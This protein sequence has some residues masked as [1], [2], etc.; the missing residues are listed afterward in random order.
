MV[1]CWKSPSG[2][3]QTKGTKLNLLPKLLPKVEECH[4]HDGWL[5]CEGVNDGGSVEVKLV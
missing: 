5:T 4:S 2:K 1:A 3:M